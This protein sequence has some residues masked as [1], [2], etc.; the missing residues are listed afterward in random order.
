MLAATV[1]RFAPDS[2]L[3][4]LEVTD[5]PEPEAREHW[6]TVDVRAAGLNHHDLWSL[7]GV[8]LTAEQLPMILGTDAAGVTP[9]GSEVV[10]HGVIGADG[11]GVGP[12]ERRSL[13]SERYPG[14]LAERVAVPTANLLPKPE[15]LSFAEAACLPTAWLTAYRMLFR[16]ADLRPGDRV[17]V[18]GVGGG[19]ATAAIVLG[20]AAGLEVV[21]TSR[22]EAKRARALELGAAHAVAP[23]D[24]LPARVDA[25]VESVGQATWAHSV[26]SVRPG[27]TIVVCGATSGDAPPAELTRVFFTEIRVQ[28]VTMGSR[29]DLAALLRFCARTG[30]RPVVDSEVRLADVRTG[31]ARL[32]AGEQ[33][34]KIVVLP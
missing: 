5:R 4:A 17:L 34:G 10:V 29:E 33:T 6:T 2:P 31:L 19:V 7:R 24:R 1:A 9:D 15:G 14:T 22:D 18:Q 16:A 28:G 21:A 20:A 26:R 8:G 30:V 23:G 11:H 25:V 3:D 12:R 27:G 13:L 32:A